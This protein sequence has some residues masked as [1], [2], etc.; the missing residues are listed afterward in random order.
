MKNFFIFFG[1]ILNDF[2]ID[3]FITLYFQKQ[4]HIITLIN[5]F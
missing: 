4:L 2:F 5:H 1:V 3:F